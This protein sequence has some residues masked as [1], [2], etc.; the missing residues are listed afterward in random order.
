MDKNREF[1]EGIHKDNNLY[2]LTNSDPDYVYK[3]HDLTKN[4]SEPHQH[5][6]EIGVG[7]GRS[8]ARLAGLQHHVYAVDISEDGL[9][10][11]KSYATTIQ[12]HNER[13]WPKNKI[14]IALCHLVFQHCDDRD[15]SWIMKNVLESLT[16]EGFFTFQS[17]DVEE[18]NL[19][20]Q[21]KKYVEEGHLFF[22]SR[23]QIIRAV[24]QFGGEVVNISDDILH[25][26]ECNIIW[27]IYR[28]GKRNNL[29][30]SN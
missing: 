5:I 10:K 11:V 20:V 9:E 8:V 7:T 30:I 1:W 15:F 14:D 6:L 29:L 2:W 16:S 26:K 19:N 24:C 17:A 28:I 18:S 21:L 4:I 25:P 12:V 13:K 23:E 3:L 27:N 22:R